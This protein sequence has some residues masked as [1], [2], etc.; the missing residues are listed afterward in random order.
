MFDRSVVCPPTGLYSVYTLRHSIKRRPTKKKKVAGRPSKF[1]FRTAINHIN[2]IAPTTLLPCDVKQQIQPVSQD[3][4]CLVE[5]TCPL[6]IDLVDSPIE[7]C[8]C[9]SIVCTKCLLDKIERSASIQCPV[10]DESHLNDLEGIQRPSSLVMSILGE[11]PIVC[12]LCSAHMQLGMYKEHRQSECQRHVL[13]VVT[14][15]ELLNKPLDSPLLPAEEKLHTQLTKRYMA[16]ST[17]ENILQVKT[18]GQVSK[19]YTHA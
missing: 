6:C 10:C 11:L 16:T 19:I 13:Q 1:S 9:R 17:H 7:L 4:S 12:A 18:G 2:E 8:A 15:D 5:L 3:S 14:V